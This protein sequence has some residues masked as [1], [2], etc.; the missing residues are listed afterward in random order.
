MKLVDSLC[1]ILLLCLPGNGLRTAFLRLKERGG[2]LQSIVDRSESST[3]AAAPLSP[4]AASQL[5]STSAQVDIDAELYRPHH[6]AFIVDG[7]GRWAINKGLPRTEGH[8]RGANVTVNIIK[9]AFE[10]KIKYVTLYLFS[11]ENWKRP[12]QEIMNIMCLLETYLVEFMDYLVENGIKVEVIGQ[13]NRLPDSVQRT[14]ARVQNNFRGMEQNINATLC[15]ALS[16]GG[17]DDILEACKAM[18]DDVRRNRL[19]VNEIDENTFSSRY[20]STGKLGIPDPDLIVRTSG[21]FRLSNFLLWQAAY[22]ELESVSCLWPE[23]TVQHLDEILE[24]FG[25]RERRFGGTNVSGNSP[26][27]SCSSATASGL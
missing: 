8:R 25:R 7:N 22:T 27:Y 12:D 21:E 26:P 13:T 15:L 4:W 16:Y 10:Y 17:R 14:L 11:T 20:I 23:F 1:L 6:V 24:R 18:S 3:A 2:K 19:D 9:K 5:E